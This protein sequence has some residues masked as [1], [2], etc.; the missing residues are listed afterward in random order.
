VIEPAVLIPYMT[1]PRDSIYRRRFEL[2]ILHERAANVGEFV[3]ALAPEDRSLLFDVGLAELRARAAVAQQAAIDGS[4]PLCFVWS[5]RS[6]SLREACGRA[7]ALM[8][9]QSAFSCRKAISKSPKP[10]AWTERHYRVLRKQ[11]APVLHYW[12]AAY[13]IAGGSPNLDGLTGAISSPLFEKLVLGAGEFMADLLA[14]R[15]SETYT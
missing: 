1:F 13:S 4:L 5:D 10:R 7:A 3:N 6:I 15:A 9:E 11:Y 14:T 8:R 12:M 2:A